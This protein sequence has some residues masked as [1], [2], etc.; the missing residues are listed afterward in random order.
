MKTLSDVL[1]STV[2][3]TKIPFKLIGRAFQLLAD[4]F[5]FYDFSVDNFLKNYKMCMIAHFYENNVSSLCCQPKDIKERMSRLTG[6][7]IADI[8]S[9]PSIAKYLKESNE[10]ANGDEELGDEEFMVR[11]VHLRDSKRIAKI[12][13]YQ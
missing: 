12:I 7:N 2:F 9:L 10:V 13:A 3:S 5:L 11:I 6:E 8:K 4:V 1:E